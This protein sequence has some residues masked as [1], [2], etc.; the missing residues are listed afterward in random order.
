[1][2]LLSARKSQKKEGH[3]PAFAFRRRHT[4]SF[5]LSHSL[6]PCPYVYLII[7]IYIRHTHMKCTNCAR[8]ERLPRFKPH[9]RKLQFQNHG[10]LPI[11]YDATKLQRDGALLDNT[12]VLPPSNSI[13]VT[14]M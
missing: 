3:I 10:T 1:M 2:Y 8:S 11:R 9:D 14:K 7:Y 6:L 4:I 13:E 12:A 5:S